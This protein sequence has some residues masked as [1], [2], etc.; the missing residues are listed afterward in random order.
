VQIYRNY[1]I[2][3]QVLAASL[4]S[5]S[6]VVQCAKAGAGIATLPLTVLDMMFN[7]PLTD[8]G[9]QIFLDDYNK[10]FQEQLVGSK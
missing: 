6:H 3:T 7:H 10:V 2:K 1:D 9:L 4:R 5:S 8:K